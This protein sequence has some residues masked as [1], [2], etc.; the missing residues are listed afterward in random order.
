M[1]WAWH[2]LGLDWTKRAEFHNVAIIALA[3]PRR[4]SP[5][6]F[7]E[8]STKELLKVESSK[9]KRSFSLSQAPRLVALSS[10]WISFETTFWPQVVWSIMVTWHYTCHRVWYLPPRFPPHLILLRR[11]VCFIIWAVAW[12]RSNRCV[13]STSNSN[14]SVRTI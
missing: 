4:V 7:R 12:K 10:T 14:S 8:L 3:S 2:T 5:P 13:F 9:S 11:F 6:S 1:S